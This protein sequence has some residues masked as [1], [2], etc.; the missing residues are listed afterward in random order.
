M[1]PFGSGAPE[2]RGGGMSRRELLLALL[3][4]PMWRPRSLEGLSRSVDAV[5]QDHL[6]VRVLTLNHVSFGCADLPE[7]VAWYERVLGI[8]R[9]AFQD[10]GGGGL[11]QT[12]LRVGIDPP[13]YMALSPRAP[14]PVDV[15]PDRRPHFCWGIEDFDVHRI[16]GALAEMR[17]L[18]RS[19][20]REGTTINGVNFDGPDG[21]PLQFNPVIA[22][23]GVGFLG[24]V[25][26]TSAAPVRRPG[27][28][29]PIQVH[30]MNHIQY[31]VSDMETALAA[32]AEEGIGT[33]LEYKFIANDAPA[34]DPDPA[35]R[36]PMEVWEAYLD[37]EERS[38]GTVIQLM[39]LREVSEDSDVQYVANPADG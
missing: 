15:P 9:Y 21:A 29:P 6:P 36:R 27:D 18:A 16:L 8:P 3:A 20:L 11:G 25:C 19:V 32:L 33:V 23:G 17:A 12:V 34:S 14:W 13:A 7:T 5:L 26:D 28:P 2:G 1:E 31:Y 30:T 38:G 24:E 35:R 10:Y 39:Q 4:A 22:C 37:T